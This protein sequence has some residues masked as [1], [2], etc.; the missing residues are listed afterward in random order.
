[1]NRRPRNTRRR[2]F[3]RNGRTRNTMFNSRSVQI[4][5]TPRSSSLTVWNSYTLQRTFS[6]DN[7]KSAFINLGYIYD[8]LV[9]L[10]GLTGTPTIDVRIISWEAYDL[11]GRPIAINVYDMD[12]EV[13]MTNTAQTSL[14]RTAYDFPGRNNWARVKV[15]IPKAISANPVTIATGYTGAAA[16]VQVGAPLG[17]ANVASKNVLLRVRLLWQ[18]NGPANVGQI[19]PNLFEPDYVDQA[20]LSISKSGFTHGSNDIKSE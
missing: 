10:L 4:A 1:M 3:R 7:N 15:I 17:I 11:A 13:S 6:V 12:T 8:A 20:V 9:N 2:R 5:P 19:R 14:L 18:T 16:N